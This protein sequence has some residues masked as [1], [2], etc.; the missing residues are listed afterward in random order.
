MPARNK[1]TNLFIELLIENFNQNPDIPIDV[2]LSVDGAII[3]G[4]L[5]TEKAFFNLNENSPLKM[6][7]LDLMKDREKYFENDWVHT[8][9]SHLTEEEISNIPDFLFQQTMYLKNAHYVINN[10]LF[11]P[12]GT[13]IQ[14]RVSDISSFSIGLLKC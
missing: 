5:V 9:K 13:S 12:Q 1:S 6:L 4:S 2:T 8:M 10:T 11:P 7:F 14:V 3:T